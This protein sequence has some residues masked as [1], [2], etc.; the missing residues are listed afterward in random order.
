MMKQ[1]EEHPGTEFSSVPS[2]HNPLKVV[3]FMYTNNLNY[4]ESAF[5]FFA[6]FYEKN[7]AS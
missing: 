7:L 1:N 3:N 5:F 6:S 4:S 2:Q